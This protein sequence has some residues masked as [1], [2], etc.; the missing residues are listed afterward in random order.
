[1]NDNQ[2]VPTQNILKIFNGVEEIKNTVVTAPDGIKISGVI[3]Q[4]NQK[5]K[6][7]FNNGFNRDFYDEVFNEIFGIHIHSGRKEIS[8]I[9]GEYTNVYKLSAE[10]FSYVVKFN[11]VGASDRS[12]WIEK[13]VYNSLTETKKRHHS[14]HIPVVPKG[15]EPFEIP[16]NR[17]DEKGE[18]FIEQGRV[19]CLVMEYY[20]SFIY[21]TKDDI[22]GALKITASILNDL[23]CFH[24]K[25]WIHRD[26]K[27]RNIVKKGNQYIIIDWESAVIRDTASDINNVTGTPY[28][29]HPERYNKKEGKYIYEKMVDTDLYSVGIFLL[30]L[31]SS[32][33]EFK[34]LF[35]K[36]PVI[37]DKE[38]EGSSPE[39][40][41]L[42]M[43]KVDNL[44]SLKISDEALRKKVYSIVEKACVWKDFSTAKRC[45]FKNAGAMLSA[46]ENAVY[47]KKTIKTSGIIDRKDVQTPIAFGFMGIIALITSLISAFIGKGFKGRFDFISLVFPYTLTILLFVGSAFLYEKILCGY[48]RDKDGERPCDRMAHLDWALSSLISFLTCVISII[49]ASVKVDLSSVSVVFYL[50]YYSFMVFMCIA[51]NIL[52][53]SG[54]ATPFKII[55]WA[56][57]VVAAVGSFHSFL[58]LGG[59]D[60]MVYAILHSIVLNVITALLIIVWLVC[61]ITLGL[62]LFPKGV[63]D[64]FWKGAGDK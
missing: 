32:E 40:Y 27:P 51:F 19:R 5:L 31:I 52:L 11:Y 12:S 47:E 21:E 13:N 29:A 45:G 44:L 37:S 34:G 64:L 26:I 20:E 1:M 15:I 14:I 39:V 62:I 16:V 43:T 9:G 10:G 55:L 58:T 18:V 22:K 63:I 35:E 57:L 6:I 36:V 24:N 23:S 42:D 60:A 33:G 30:E 38:E 25:G 4:E 54:K 41:G 2:S 50:A 17:Y 3:N 46:V 48:L 7:D 28:Y 56:Y 53:K 8:D 61:L 59:P 49:I